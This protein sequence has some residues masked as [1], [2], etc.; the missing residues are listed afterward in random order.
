MEIVPMAEQRLDPGQLNIVKEKC[1]RSPIKYSR[2]V[3]SSSSNFLPQV[4]VMV[5][6]N[7]IQDQ[8]SP[9]IASS[10]TLLGK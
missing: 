9:S 5:G 2:C 7:Q 3:T 6:S 8:L 10:R 1:K 4:K